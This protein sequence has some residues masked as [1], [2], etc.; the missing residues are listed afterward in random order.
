MKVSK[1]KACC[2]ACA[3]TSTERASGAP[4]PAGFLNCRAP[5]PHNNK[6]SPYDSLRRASD[7]CFAFRLRGDLAK[8]EPEVVGRG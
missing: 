6:P 1:V 8:H 3:H 5:E 7:W 2:G 4:V